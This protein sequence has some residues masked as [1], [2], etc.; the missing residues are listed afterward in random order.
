MVDVAIKPKAGGVAPEKLAG[1]VANHSLSLMAT[2][3]FPTAQLHDHLWTRLPEFQAW[4]G[5]ADHTFLRRLLCFI[6][7][8]RLDSK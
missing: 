4:T 8:N 6:K 2:E 5:S 1:P 7:D 3:T